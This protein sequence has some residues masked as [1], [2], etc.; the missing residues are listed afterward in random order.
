MHDAD[1]TS[2][3]TSA[4][5]EADTKMVFENPSKEHDVEDEGNQATPSHSQSE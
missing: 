2:K 3:N 5:D 1:Q 4:E